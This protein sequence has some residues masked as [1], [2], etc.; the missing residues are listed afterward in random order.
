MKTLLSW[1]IEIVLKILKKWRIAAMAFYPFI[2]YADE[3]YMNREYVIYQNLHNHEKIHHAQQIEMLWIGFYLL[4]LG[5]YFYFRLKGYGHRKAYKSL[6]FEREASKNERN[7]EYLK[8][9]KIYSWI[10]YIN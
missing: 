10:K 9:R 5:Q 4:Y 2:S 3:R 6:C 1:C 7:L 8:T